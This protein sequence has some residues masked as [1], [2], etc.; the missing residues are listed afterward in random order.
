[1][2]LVEIDGWATAAKTVGKSI[3]TLKRWK[4]SYASELLDSNGVYAREYAKAR[5]KISGSCED[6]VLSAYRKALR[7]LTKKLDEDM[8]AAELG[9]I[10]KL[11][12]ELRITHQEIALVD[13][14]LYGEEEA[15]KDA[16]K[17]PAEA[18][19]GAKQNES[20]EPSSED[21]GDPADAEELAAA[22][23]LARLHPGSAG[24][25]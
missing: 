11:T 18:A 8:S 5:R 15:P 4:G 7:K 10:V 25:H 1:M 13:R 20:P 2:L 3:D 6:L 24:V 21:E 17:P 12:G 16:A 9:H 22:R 23:E 19:A 14:D